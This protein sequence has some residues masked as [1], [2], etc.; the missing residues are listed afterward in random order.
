MI[1]V[2]IFGNDNN[3]IRFEI[4]IYNQVPILVFL[5]P[6]KRIYK[7]AGQLFT[8]NYGRGQIVKFGRI[9]HIFKNDGIDI[10]MAYYRQY[11]TDVITIVIKNLIYES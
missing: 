6:G 1:R 7:E 2:K 10:G 8:M 3:I 5:S 9:S 11:K 4:S